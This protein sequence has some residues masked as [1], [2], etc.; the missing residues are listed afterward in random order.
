MDIAPKSLSQRLPGLL[1]GDAEQL[2]MWIRAPGWRHTVWCLLVIAVGAG[3]Y[4]AS[5]GAWRSPLQA[6]YAAIKLPLILLLTT[7]GNSLLNAS[8]APLMGVAISPRQTMLA[9]LSSFAL[10]S[11]ILGSFAPLVLFQV[12]SLPAAVT[13][14][15]LGRGSF[16][17]GPSTVEGSILLLT[18]VG[19][20][21]FAG[22]AANLRLLQLLRALSPAP[23]VAGRVL[24]GWLAGNFLLGTQLTWIFRPFFGSPTLAVEFLRE[25]PLRGG[26]FEALWNN[27]MLAS[28]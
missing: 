1:R 15:D 12:W 24:L 3:A 17:I 14:D 18:N 21:A 22:I 4:G 8:L 28:H 10:A 19:V 27:F 11:A 20:I 2:Q 6:W 5:I 23:G 13:I 25:H 7:A 26:F 16:A 9:L